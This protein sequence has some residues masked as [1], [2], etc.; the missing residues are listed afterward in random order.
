MAIFMTHHSAPIVSAIPCFRDN[1]IWH[2]ATDAGSYVVDPGDGDAVLSFLHHQP[3]ELIGILITHHHSDHVGGVAQLKAHYP[4]LQVY[5][6]AEDIHELDHILAAPCTL[7]LPGLGEIQVVNVAGHTR[8]HIAYYSAKHQLLF[9]GDSLFSAGCGRLFEGTYAQLL[10]AM[11]QFSQLPT[12]TKVFPAHE[13]TQANLAFAQAVEPNNVTIKAHQHAVEAWRAK[14]QPS[15]P[16]TIGLEL[17]IN[18]FLRYQQDTVRAAVQDRVDELTDLTV[19]TE[20]RRWKDT[21]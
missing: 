16:S 14:N 13:Y 1:Y 18:P 21:F 19:L 7:T 9:C 5:G 4:K 6:P 17:C 11:Q 15:L 8:A 3:A 12:D 2:L 10:A 20:L